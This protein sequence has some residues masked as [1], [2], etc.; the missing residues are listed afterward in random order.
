MTEIS[1][2]LLTNLNLKNNKEFN[3]TTSIEK[4]KNDLSEHY[5][6]PTLDIHKPSL[7]F[8]N[9]YIPISQKS[10]GL[11]FLTESESVFIY[12]L[13][14]DIQYLLSD[15]VLCVK[16]PELTAPS[17][18]FYAYT[19]WLGIKMVKKIELIYTTGANE[20]TIIDSYNRN[21]VLFYSKCEITDNERKMYNRCIGQQELKQGEYSNRTS[22]FT[23]VMW[24][25]DGLQ[26]YKNTQ[27][28]TYLWIPLIFN[29]C[30]DTKK[31]FANIA[32]R[33]FRI[34]VTFAKTSDILF[35]YDST[36]VQQT[37][38]DTFSDLRIT[39]KMY[40]NLIFTYPAY[41]NAI[42]KLMQKQIFTQRKTEVLPITTQTGII[43]LNTTS[44]PIKK[45]YIA[46]QDPLLVND[47]NH[48]AMFGRTTKS[49]VYGDTNVLTHANFEWSD[50]A[51]DYELTGYI[52]KESCDA[53]LN[54][55]LK[56]LKV[57]INDIPLYSNSENSFYNSYIPLKFIQNGNNKVNMIDDSVLVIDLTPFHDSGD[58]NYVNS[59][60][61]NG[62][63]NEENRIS[64]EYTLTSQIDCELVY[65]IVYVNVLENNTVTIEKKF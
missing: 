57:L 46:F 58:N 35:L 33:Q 59:F 52:C 45:I 26:T 1:R 40:C 11:K 8:V 16:L 7:R 31:I 49:Y 54:S 4:Y 24:Y 2:H 48:W 62:K 53:S 37:L 55:I 18:Y 27:P 39:S 34:R 65:S 13:P 38:N 30:T 29:F 28:E 14:K 64:I 17:G 32:N 3:E 43:K 5:M 21:D 44:L 50:V 42:G 36:L 19:S 41:M 61:Q 60:I 12:D 47:I 6:I 22:A 51:A 9:N 15:C 10:S 23:G 63:A 20:D 25:K 56:T